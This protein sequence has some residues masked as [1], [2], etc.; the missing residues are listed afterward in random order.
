MILVGLV[1]GQLLSARSTSST[2]FALLCAVGLGA[3]FAVFYPDDS[4]AV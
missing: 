3:Q 1:M 2:L 4:F